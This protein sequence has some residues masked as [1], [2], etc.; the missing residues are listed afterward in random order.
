MAEDTRSKLTKA[1]ESATKLN[2]VVYAVSSGTQ[3]AET[4]TA[5]YAKPVFL[6]DPDYK[7]VKGA[8]FVYGS[9]GK[10]LIEP[11]YNLII[12]GSQYGISERVSRTATMDG[13]VRRFLGQAPLR[14]VFSIGLF[15][16][17]NHP[18]KDQ[19]VYLWNEVLRGSVL[20]AIGAK[21]YVYCGGD[22]F[23]GDMHSCQ[24]GRAATDGVSDGM[25]GASIQM[26][27]DK[28]P[29]PYNPALSGVTSD[30]EV[31]IAKD[32][33]DVIEKGM[34]VKKVPIWD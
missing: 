20:Q 22:I 32:I 13:E 15:D 14:V 30:A 11:F 17:R 8:L 16:Y 2:R 34:I 7:D 1:R 12:S 31:A 10:K 23:V 27:C 25:V 21:V 18:W 33:K 5:A 26:D 4:D 19:F 9:D 6:Q 29:I 24:F 3:K 28:S